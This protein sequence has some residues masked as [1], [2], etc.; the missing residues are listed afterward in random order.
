MDEV[1]LKSLKRYERLYDEKYFKEARSET[2]P[3]ENNV[4]DLQD[5]IQV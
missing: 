1:Q 2:P 4:Q 3:I 5:T